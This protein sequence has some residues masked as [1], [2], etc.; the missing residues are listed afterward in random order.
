MTRVLRIGQPEFR[1][2]FSDPDQNLPA[3]S[4]F[5]PAK[6]RAFAGAKDDKDDLPSA[7]RAGEFPQVTY[8][9]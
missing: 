5:A 7:V 2:A 8:G 3:S 9:R 4:P 6:G 1:A